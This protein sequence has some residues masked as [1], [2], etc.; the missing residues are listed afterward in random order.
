MTDE[1]IVKALECCTNEHLGCEDGCP[2]ADVGCYDEDGFHTIPMKDALDLI[3]RQKAEIEQKDIEIDILIRKKEALRD[4]ICE[5]QSEV[6][7]LKEIEYMYNSL[8]N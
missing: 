8:L 1:Q 6:E 2:Y 3:N 5:L 7:R 4:E